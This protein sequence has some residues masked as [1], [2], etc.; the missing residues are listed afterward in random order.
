VGGGCAFRF[1]ATAC[2]DSIDSV[3]HKMIKK[4]QEKKHAPKRKRN[5]ESVK[6]GQGRTEKAKESEVRHNSM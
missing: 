4:T 1:P 2:I 3:H 5:K 6:T